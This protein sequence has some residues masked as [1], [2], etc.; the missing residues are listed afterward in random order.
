MERWTSGRRIPF[1]V[2]PLH[3]ILPFYGDGRRSVAGTARE[4]GG[5]GRWVGRCPVIGAR[6][7]RGQILPD[8]RNYAIGR[9]RSGPAQL[10][11]LSAGSDL[12]NPST[13]NVRTNIFD[14]K[15]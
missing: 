4:L 14:K 2:A 5:A 3:D 6:K 10:A 7:T 11:M 9:W 8:D 15:N 12:A 1:R 13:Q